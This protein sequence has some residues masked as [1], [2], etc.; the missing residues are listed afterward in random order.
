MAMDDDDRAQRMWALLM[1][2]GAGIHE[3]GVP[4][5]DLGRQRCPACRDAAGAEM[6]EV[7]RGLLADFRAALGEG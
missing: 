7:A 5:P 4:V 1:D 3:A 6:N 2:H